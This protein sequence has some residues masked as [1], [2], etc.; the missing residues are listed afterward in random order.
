MSP[1][2][3]LVTTPLVNNDGALLQLPRGDEHEDDFALLADIFPTGY[4]AATLAEVG[5]G[6]SV[7]VF[8]AG[9]V[10]LMAAYSAMIKGAAKVFV[11]DKV[12]GRL[13]LVEQ[14]GA[15]PIDFSKGDPVAQIKPGSTAQ[16]GVSCGS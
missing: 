16:T 2:K 14:I 3:S 10:G 8:G 7:C 1:P 4:R 11:V 13:K 9:P 5:P 15:V 6:E 12:P